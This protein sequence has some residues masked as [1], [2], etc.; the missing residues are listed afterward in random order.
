MWGMKSKSLQIK[1][2]T[3]YKNVITVENHLQDGG[4]GSWLNESLV[5]NGNLKNKVN[6]MSK[7]LDANV[8]GQVG[9]EEYLSSRFGPK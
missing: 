5:I 4:F 3:K 7:F 9:S 2:L 6:I 1:K 8:I